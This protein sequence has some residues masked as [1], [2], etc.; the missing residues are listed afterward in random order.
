MSDNELIMTTIES[1]ETDSVIITSDTTIAVSNDAPPPHGS[2][3]SERFLA[4]LLFPVTIEY[5]DFKGILIIT[6]TI[7][8]GDDYD[9]DDDAAP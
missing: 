5:I 7:S 9:V 6:L 3:S 8:Y 4:T 2:S 1:H